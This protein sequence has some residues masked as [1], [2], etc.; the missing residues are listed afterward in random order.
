M[1][2][3]TSLKPY[4]GCAGLSRDIA[5]GEPSDVDVGGSASRNVAAGELSG[6]DVGRTPVVSGEYGG[7]SGDIAGGE[8]SGV[9]VGG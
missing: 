7:A 4:H 1:L 5:A 9:E 3:P 2:S 6:V 8:H